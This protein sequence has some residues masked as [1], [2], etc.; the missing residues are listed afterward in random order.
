MRIMNKNLYTTVID[1]L[2]FEPFLET[3]HITVGVTEEGV[4]TLRGK[5]SS[6]MQKKSAEAAL[7]KL[8]DVTAIANDLEVESGGFHSR[9]DT[10]IAEEA[11]TCLKY[12]LAPKEKIKIGVENGWITLTGEVEYHFQKKDAE[13]LMHRLRGVRGITNLITLHQKVS[14]QDVKNKIMSEFQRNAALDAQHIQV[15]TEGDTVTLKGR[16]RFCY[17]KEEAETA[18]WKIPGVREVRNHLKVS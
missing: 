8:K 9:D 4:V 7:K 6:Y 18:V 1:Q 11:V 10:S 17:E 2:N 16:V 3:A 15:E 14:P 13:T 5:V 12:S